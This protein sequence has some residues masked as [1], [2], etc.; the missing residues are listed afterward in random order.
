MREHITSRDNSL[1]RLA[2]KLSGSRSARR[3]SGLFVCDGPTLLPEALAKGTQVVSVLCVENMTLPPLPPDTRIAELPERLMH[4]ICPT[5]T[6]QGLL[7]V[8]RL[9]D[10]TPPAA[11]TEGRYLLLDRVQD[12]GN[13]G[14]ILR[15]AAAFSASGVL[16]GPGCADPFSP[17]AV[18]AAMG[19][20]FG[21]PVYETSDVIEMLKGCALPIY[22]AALSDDAGD[23]RFACLSSCVL[24]LGNESAGLSRELLDRADARI[25]IPMDAACQ[26]LGVAAAAAVLLWEAS[27]NT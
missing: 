21:L 12:P 26:S 17:K 24:L 2:V 22:A 16:L 5:D 27:R 13:V 18:R 7:F 15:T 19:T 8:C 25:K 1:V 6:P 11:L 20:A 23:V 14:S 9:P 10:T 3:A 4:A